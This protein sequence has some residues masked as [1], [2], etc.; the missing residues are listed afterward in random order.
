MFF[1]LKSEP[2]LTK[3][4]LS[5]TCEAFCLSF[6]VLLSAQQLQKV[7]FHSCLHMRSRES[8]TSS[9]TIFLEAVMC[10]LFSNLIVFAC[11]RLEKIESVSPFV[12]DVVRVWDN[13]CEEKD[14]TAMHL[15]DVNMSTCLTLCFSPLLKRTMASKTGK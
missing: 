3:H 7:V 12:C 4:F 6:G 13:P 14:V 11:L 5:Q 1:L 10:V 2:Q 8:I 15:Q 9:G